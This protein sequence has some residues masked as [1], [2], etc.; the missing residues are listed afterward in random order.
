MNRKAYRCKN[1]YAVS[2]PELIDGY[3]ITEENRIVFTGTED[4]AGPYLTKDTEVVDCT[5]KFIMPGFH[6]FHVHL[7]MGAM[8]EYGGILRYAESEEEAAR[9]IWENNKDR[10]DSEWIFGGAWDHFRWPGCGLPSKK[11]LDRYFPGTK[12]FLLNK[13]CHGAWMNSKALEYFNITKDTPD[14]KDGY[15]SRDEKGEPDGYLHESATFLPLVEICE[16]CGDEQIAEYT[17]AYAKTANSFGITSVGDVALKNSIRES[18]YRLLDDRGELNI[19][20]HFAK[21]MMDDLESLIKLKGDYC[22]ERV[23]FIGTKDFIDGTPMGH[24]G[25]MLEDY[26]DMPGFRSSPLIQREEL[27]QRVSL[28]H[29]H[30]IKVRLHACGDAGV[31]LCLDAFEI[32][33]KRYGIKDLR[34][35]VEHIEAT[36]PEDI[37]R[38]AELNVIAS[39]QPEHLPKYDF[40]NHPFHSMIGE[41]RMKYSWPFESLRKSGAVLAYGTDFPV[42]DMS[43]FRGIYRSVA[44]LTNEGE[45][46]GGFNPE[47]RVGI[48]ETLKAYTYGSAFAAGREHEL[49]TLEAGKLADFIVLNENLFQCAEDRDL[50][51]AIRPVMTVMDGRTVYEQR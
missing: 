4:S 23:R 17:K 29:E 24:T 36:T 13:E 10:L 51:F 42:A 20:I 40:K 34:H 30:D 7:L 49:G 37:K 26:T 6:D 14:P 2:A 41:E 19:R 33:E 38:F 9:M 25:Y 16:A 50:M 31:R 35:C 27:I 15:F 11:S 32:A 47:E 1:I 46:E 18:G 39:V 44:R 43:P 8:A 12:V 5:E 3:L 22:G 48:H 21:P 45:P 28:M